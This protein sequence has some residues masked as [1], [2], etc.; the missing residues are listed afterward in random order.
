MSW[1]TPSSAAMESHVPTSLDAALKYARRGWP[2]FPTRNKAP[3]TRHGFIDATCD[4]GVITAWFRHWPRAG[5]AIATGQV[6]A[7]VVV[8]VDPRNGGDRVLAEIEGTHGDLPLT[9]RVRTPN[10]GHHH[11]FALPPDSPRLAATLGDGIDLKGDGGYVVAPPSHLEDG[12]AYCWDDT[13]HLNEVP[14]APAP[15]WILVPRRSGPVADSGRTIGKDAADSALGRLFAH[16]GYLGRPLVD[17]KRACRCPWADTHSDGRGIGVDSSTVLFPPMPGATLGGFLC[18]HGHCASRTWRD[19]LVWA[20]ADSL[21]AV[22]LT[23]DCATAWEAPISF[24][25]F[26]VPTFPV[27]ALPAWMAAWGAA[28]ATALQVP[29]DLPAILAINTVSLL[30]S[31]SIAVEINED[32]QEPTNLYAAIALPPGEGKSPVFRQA[33]APVYDWEARERARLAPLIAEAEERLR[34]WE[35]R[36]KEL[37]RKAARAKTDLDLERA[38]QKLKELTVERAGLRIPVP[39]RLVADDATP[40]AVGILLG[41]QGGRLGIFSSEGGPFEILAGRYSDKGA[42]I[43]LFLN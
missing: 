42:N 11:Y 21:E 33:M 17:G 10:G 32:W 4:A 19:V 36:A 8:D 43:E 15:S 28:E 41:L 37:R 39:A 2:V 7:L 34:V 25:D 5:V 26:E 38:E 12:R 40:E 16:L 31:K 13:G 35:E 1:G 30:I 29:T 20:P 9:P 23:R 6:S 24:D 3:L 27:D 14:V 22:G 18:S